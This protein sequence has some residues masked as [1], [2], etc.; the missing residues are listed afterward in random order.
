MKFAIE[1]VI[2]GIAPDAYEALYFDEAFT[3][4]LAVELALGRQLLRLDRT[5]ARIVR[6]TCYDAKHDPSTPAGQAFGSSRAAYVEELDYDR[7]ARRGS[8]RTVPSLMP[9]RVR[10]TGTI[11]IAAAPTGTR[12]TV[13]G[14]VKVSLFGFGGIVERM[15]VAEIEKS[16]ATAARFTAAW[17]A[18]PR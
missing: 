7:T 3:A 14:E 10:N 18:R 17:L 12:R 11:E 16:Y 15:I 6:H 5:P 4:A 8:W 13:R 9:E 2:E 1:H